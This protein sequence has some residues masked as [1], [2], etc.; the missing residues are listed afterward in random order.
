MLILISVKA[1]KSPLSPGVRNNENRL[2]VCKRFTSEIGASGLVKC[3][4]IYN[5]P[6]ELE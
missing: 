5:E 6:G 1:D 3:I 2:Y 4:R